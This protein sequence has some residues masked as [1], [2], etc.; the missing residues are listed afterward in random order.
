MSDDDEYGD[1]GFD[2]YDDEF[3]DYDDEPESKQSAGGGG[4]GGAAAASSS[5]VASPT[6]GGKIPAYEITRRRSRAKELRTMVTLSAESSE[7]LSLSKLSPYDYYLRCVKNGALRQS[8]Q[9]TNADKR[10]V[11]L[12]TDSISKSSKHCQVPDDLGFSASAGR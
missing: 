12:Q 6:N 2:D 1:D 8:S 5:Y 9:Q 3:D 11:K 10:G 4:G 7:L